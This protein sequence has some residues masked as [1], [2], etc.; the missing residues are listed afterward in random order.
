MKSILITP[1]DTSEFRLIVDA[2]SK[3]GVKPDLLTDDEK[4]DIASAIMMRDGERSE[5]KA[6]VRKLY[7]GD[8]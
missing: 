6:L 8:F 1:K 3:I 2:L 5:G 7:H 4:D